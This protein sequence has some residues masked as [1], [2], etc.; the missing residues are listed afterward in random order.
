MQHFINELNEK[1]SCKN[2]NSA[3]K[4]FFGSKNCLRLLNVLLEDIDMIKQQSEIY[5][6]DIQIS[7]PD[8]ECEMLDI[9]KWN[10]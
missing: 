4:T 3:L 2:D 9:T 1:K 10:G 7:S 8:I 6:E 5:M